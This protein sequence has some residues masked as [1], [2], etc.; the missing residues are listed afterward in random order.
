MQHTYV[1]SENCVGQVIDHPYVAFLVYSGGQEVLLASSC[2]GIIRCV[3][4]RSE[5]IAELIYACSEM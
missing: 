1:C 5:C 4:D 3:S 2:L